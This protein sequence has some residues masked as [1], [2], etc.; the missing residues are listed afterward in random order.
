MT[1]IIIAAMSMVHGLIH[2]FGFAR[3]FELVEIPQLV[4]PISHPGGGGSSAP[5]PWRPHRRPFSPPQGMTVWAPSRTLC[6]S[7]Q[8]HMASPRGAH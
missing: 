3:A 1:R 6:S 8:S 2:F 7:Q 4:Q 5:V